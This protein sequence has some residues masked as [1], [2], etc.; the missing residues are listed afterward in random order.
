MNN[1]LLRKILRRLLS[2]FFSG[3]I[4]LVPLVTTVYII[5]YLFV[6]LDN[7]L[8]FQETG[9]GILV[10]IGLLTFIGFLGNTII[11][12]PFIAWFNKLL[13]RMPLI[14]T[15]YVSI[16]DLLSAFVGKKKGF[17]QPVLVQLN[18]QE[19]LYKF[20]FITTDDLTSLGLGDNHIA[21]YLPH[22]YNFSGNLFVVHRSQIRPLDVKS[23][24]LMKFIVSAGISD[25]SHLQKDHPPSARN[26]T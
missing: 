5:Y 15:I 14:R 12:Q 13:D 23:S 18:K 20:G 4:L 10:V 21:V 22:S 2:Y 24:E 1:R 8:P 7:L 17:N 9:L 26:E 3:I 25:V 16:K 6:T 19:E 11:A